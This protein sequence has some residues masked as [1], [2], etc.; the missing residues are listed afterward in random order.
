MR[1][2]KFFGWTLCAVVVFLGIM[3]VCVVQLLESKDLSPLVEEVANDYIDGHLTMGRLKVGFHPRFP[4]LGVEIEDLS[5]TSHAFDS[6]TSAERGVL[7]DY[8]DSLLSLNYMAGSLNLKSLILDNEL[9]L[10]NVVLRGLSVNLVIAHNGKANYEVVNIPSDT[11]KHTSRKIPAFRINRFAL[12]QPRE[13]R[14][15]NAADSTSA[16]VMLLTDASVDGDKQPT[17]RLK[18]SGNITSRK[19]TLITN[20]D[21]IDFG[22]NGKIYWNPAEPGLVAMEEMELQGAFIR[23]IVTGEIDLT[24]SPVVR[25]AIVELPAVAVTDLIALLPDSIRRRHQLYEPDFATDARIKGKFELTKPMNLVTDTIPA[26]KIELSIPS[27]ALRYGDA[28][29]NELAM[30]VNMNTM[31]DSPD[32]AVIEVSRC[33][34]NGEATR[35]RASAVFSTLSSDP[36][37]DIDLHGQV[38]LT[39]LPPIIREKIQGYLA[40]GITTDLRTKGSASMLSRRHF[41]RIIA[42]GHVTARDIYFLSADIDKMVEVNNAKIDFSSGVPVGIEPVFKAELSADTASILLGG[43]DITVGSLTLGAGMKNDESQTDSAAILPVAGDL[44]VERLNIISITDSAGARISR[45]SGNI[46]FG[47]GNRGHFLPEISADLHPGHVS[48]GSLADRIILEN[49]EIHA[50]L[51]KLPQPSG[52][53]DRGRRYEPRHRA[54]R[55]ISPDS[56]LKLAYEKRHHKPGEKRKRRVYS[57]L[58]ADNNETLEWDLAKGFNRFLT[59]WKLKGT[60]NTDEARLLTPRFPLHNSFSHIGLRF[61][62]DTVDISDISLMAG[63]SDIRLSGLVTN[64]R[65]ALTSK[66]DN[67]LKINLSSVSDTIDVN[68][69]SA[70]AFV[71]AAYAQHRRHGKI[72]ITGTGNDV[73]LQARIDTLAKA[74]TASIAP[75]LIPVNINANLHLAAD[76][77]LYGDLVMQKMGGDLLVYDGAVNLHNVKASSDAGNL[78]VSALYSAPGPEDMYFGF[79]MMLDDFNIG[80]FMEI[81]PAVDSIIPLIHDFS[82][83][84][85]AEVAATCR[86]DS[87]MNFLLPTL[88]AA[89]RISGENLAFIDPRKYRLLAK[90]LGFKNKTDNT[91]RHL[92]V[93]MT[94]A[95]GLMRVYPFTFNI[96]RYRLGVYGSNDIAMNFDYHISVLKSPLP[97]KFG[98]TISGHPKKYKVRFGGAK[99]NEATAVESVDIVNEARINLIDQIE[100]VFRRGVQ[101]SRFARLQLP[102]NQVED[103]GVPDPGLNEVDS[104]QLVREGIIDAPLP[105]DPDDQQRYKPKKKHK[106]FLFF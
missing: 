1:I 57:T 76:R 9:N 74:G 30:D 80:K 3:L 37:F 25:K 14:F 34:L 29:F 98:I 40:G 88:D 64:V 11:L 75:I 10:R 20:L 77:V 35:L 96:D 73:A 94:V 16:S 90:W 60:L 78:T 87:C 46:K 21:R 45:L 19:A 83:I 31:V 85:G 17:Y 82:G 24:S 49:T 68:E 92:N 27:A 12:E 5:I 65:G 56:V 18:I 13:M 72:H 43:V 63:R 79:G 23:A 66:I 62:N 105:P 47:M 50:S 8:A 53:G 61:N 59:G 6:L 69:L 4:I 54:Y 15:Y 26:A 58:S 103:F 44:E 106:K 99:F 41:H 100:K 39:G 104:L 33:I 7:P 81:V 102:D 91:I 55:Y 52:K 70:T 36:T 28:R 101:N 2:L 93:D 38:D 89:I 48:A 84:I 51:Q 95:D 67:T 22:L 86:L 42:D 32:S 97:F 71:G